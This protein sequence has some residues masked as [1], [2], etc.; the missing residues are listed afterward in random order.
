VPPFA[1]VQNSVSRPIDGVFIAETRDDFN[2]G[3]N[4]VCNNPR[5]PDGIASTE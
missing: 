3:R 2:F 4:L 1:T 5:R